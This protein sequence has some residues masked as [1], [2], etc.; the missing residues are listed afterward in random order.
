MSVLIKG[1]EMPKTCVSCEWSCYVGNGRAMCKKVSMTDK[2]DIMTKRRADFCPLVEISTSHWIPVTE[3]LPE[4]SGRYCVTLENGY[5]K[6][7]YYNIEKTK[8]YP[9]GF[10]YLLNNGSMAWLS[11]KSPVVAWMSLPEPYEGRTE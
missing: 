10:F 9:K 3:R 2:S 6:N 7:L 11:T 1:M 5:V 8:C 4:K